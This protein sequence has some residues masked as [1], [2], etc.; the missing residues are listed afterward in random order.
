MTMPSDRIGTE[1]TVDARKSNEYLQAILKASNDQAIISTDIHGYVLTSSLGT[2]RVFGLSPDEIAGRDVLTLFLDET[3]QRELSEFI[4]NGNVQSL[5]R[6]K[7]PQ[8]RSKITCYLDVTFQ[9]VADA[10]DY[11]I[12]FL[13][14]VRDVTQ[15]VLLQERLKSLSLTDEVTGFYNQRHLFP[16]LESELA[17]SRSSKR[18]FVLCFFDL[19]GLKQY[20]DTY[21]HLRGTQV[22]KET[23]HLLRTYLRPDLDI[24][25][26]Y[27][28]DEFIVIM[29]E[30]SKHAALTVVDKIRLKLCELY[31]G[32]ITASVGISESTG[33]VDAQE[34][35]KRANQAMYRAKKSGKNCIIMWQ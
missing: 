23:A 6:K 7:L 21:G 18:S 19:D 16:T 32:K 20:N 22:I 34:L 4:A 3:F 9:L 25:Y 33:A 26:R 27:G 24:C 5:E 11:P 10:D 13:C 2:K 12:G 8:T 15:N 35:V 31:H 28:G 17:R 14:I 30:T 29:P 1:S